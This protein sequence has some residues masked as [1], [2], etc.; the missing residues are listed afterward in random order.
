MRIEHKH[1][2]TNE[3]VYRRLQGLLSDLQEQYA[4]KIKN[5][6]SQWNQDNTQMDFS[7]EIMGFRSQGRV[8]LLDKKVIL[9]GNLP[10]M[11][12]MFSGK[13]ESMIKARLEAL[14][15]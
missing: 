5:L 7:V 12:R 10:L 4:D 14:L 2:L 11:A 9:E 3:E 6:Q 1:N 13:I 8:Y 15:S